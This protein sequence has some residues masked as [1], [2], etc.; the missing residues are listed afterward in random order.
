MFGFGKKRVLQKETEK[1]VQRFQAMSKL[2]IDDIWN[3]D[4]KNNL[5][6][7]MFMYISDKCDYGKNLTFLTSTERTF[8]LCQEFESEI[9]NGGFSQFYFNS[10]GN[11]C[12]E[13]PK[14]LNEIGAMH[15]SKIVEKAN[16]LFG[17]I[18]PNDKK[19][20]E[21]LLDELVTDEMNEKLDS[22]DREFYEYKDNLTELNYAYLLVYKTDFT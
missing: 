20:R 16:A 17:Y 19:E 12:Y 22:L 2:E 11:Y 4:D 21:I 7:A 18:L 14:A 8:Y 13:T 1:S 15:T 10:S 9:N 5:V 6:I 3:I